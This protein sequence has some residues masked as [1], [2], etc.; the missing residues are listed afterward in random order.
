MSARKNLLLTGAHGFVAGSV[1][2]QAGSVLKGAKAP[3][4]PAITRAPRLAAAVIW[5]IVVQAAT[6]KSPYP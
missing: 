5:L 6:R 1:L 2:T 3:P 4:R